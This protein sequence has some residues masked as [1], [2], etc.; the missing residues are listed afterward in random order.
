MRV[1]EKQAKPGLWKI[2]AVCLSAVVLLARCW[3]RTDKENPG[4]GRR[5]APLLLALR[6]MEGCCIRGCWRFI[7]SPGRRWR[8]G[9]ACISEEIQP[10]VMAAFCFY[11]AQAQL[12]REQ[13][14]GRG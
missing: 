14:F 3:Q 2:L 13:F 6:W 10:D 12:G 1:G 4:R 7:F 9:A 11:A 8:G 5:A